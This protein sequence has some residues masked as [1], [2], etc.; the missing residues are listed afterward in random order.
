MS[1]SLVPQQRECRI[2]V[3]PGD[4]EWA[5]VFTLEGFEVWII[6]YTCGHGQAL[7][8]RSGSRSY[9]FIDTAVGQMR[10]GKRFICT[11]CTFSLDGP[12]VWARI[13]DVR[14]LR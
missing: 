12:G 7:Q 9:V 2:R 5:P 8:F 10:A 13:A 11:C 3:L 4:G 1:G 14:Q 6:R